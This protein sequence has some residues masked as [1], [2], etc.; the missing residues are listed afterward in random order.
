MKKYFTHIIIILA[1]IA[2]IALTAGCSKKTD[3]NGIANPASEN[4]VAKGGTLTIQTAADGSQSGICT[5]SNGTV[6]DEWAFYR[7][8]CGRQN[9]NTCGVCP[10]LSP[11]SPTF[12]TNGKI[13]DSG[14]N[15]CGC[16]LPPK[17]E[18]VACT[19]EAKLCPDG[20]AVGRVAPD[21]EFAP[22]PVQ[23]K[24]THVCTAAE[25]EANICT[26]DYNQV[27]GLDGK[28]YGN[29]CGACAAGVDS[30]EKGECPTGNTGKLVVNTCSPEEKARTACTREYMPVCGW[31]NETIKCFAYPCAQTF[32]NKCEACAAENVDTWTEGECPKVGSSVKY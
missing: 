30:W 2:L 11:P 6:C 27:C 4:C 3:I 26:M 31:F 25:K 10:Q 5:L 12:C 8:E 20:S 21:C 24:V 18:L 7:G 19:E 9:T 17:C 22:C 1:V 16:Q 28:T 14:K 29:G 32:G 13:I 23:P 15:E